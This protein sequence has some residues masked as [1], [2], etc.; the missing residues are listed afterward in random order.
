[1]SQNH[2][3]RH[4]RVTTPRTDGETEMPESL[5]E[6][7]GEAAQLADSLERDG[8]QLRYEIEEATGRVVAS[9]CDLGGR[10]VRVLP[11]TEALGAIDGGAPAV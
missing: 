11:L 6:E 3:D 7:I 9:L 8:L 4:S 2:T 10:R 1:M 5:W